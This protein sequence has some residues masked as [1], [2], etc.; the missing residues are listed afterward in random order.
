MID[1]PFAESK[2]LIAGYGLV[3]VPSLEEAISWPRRYIETVGAEEADLRVLAEAVSLAQSC[4][5][6]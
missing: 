1:G 2:E 6:R 4:R 3:E 5:R